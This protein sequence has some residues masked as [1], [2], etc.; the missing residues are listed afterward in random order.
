MIATTYTLEQLKIKS[1]ENYEDVPQETQHVESLYLGDIESHVF[2]DYK[3][4]ERVE[5]YLEEQE[6][7]YS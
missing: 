7:C 4:Y 2:V 3:D 6:S 1:Y 5:Q